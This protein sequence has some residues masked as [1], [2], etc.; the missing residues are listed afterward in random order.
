MPGLGELTKNNDG[1]D[2]W[3]K[4]VGADLGYPRCVRLYSSSAHFHVR[5]SL[6]R[7]NLDIW[8]SNTDEFLL[9]V[10]E[11]QQPPNYDYTETRQYCMDIVHSVT[12]AFG[13]ALT[14]ISGLVFLFRIS[15]TAF[16]RTAT[17]IIYA[18]IIWTILGATQLSLFQIFACRPLSALGTCWKDAE[19]GTCINYKPSVFAYL[20]NLMIGNIPLIVL[21]I[22]FVMRLRMRPKK[23]LFIYGIPFLAF[24]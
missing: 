1:I 18:D 4:E 22:V 15:R 16:G 24:M 2:R 19:E 7:K 12:Y 21:P 5:T 3:S 8:D 6:S 13:M 9:I 14:K 23:K 20:L 17:W 11:S 10:V